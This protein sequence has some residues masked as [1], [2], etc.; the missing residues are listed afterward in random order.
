MHNGRRTRWPGNYSRSYV[1]ASRDKA[2]PF[3]TFYPSKRISGRC[4]T[5][6]LVTPSKSTMHLESSEVESMTTRQ[7]PY[8]TGSPTTWDNRG[9]QKLGA[10]LNLVLSSGMPQCPGLTSPSNCPSLPT[11]NSRP[12][13]RNSSPISFVNIDMFLYRLANLWNLHGQPDQPHSVHVRHRSNRDHLATYVR[14][15][16]QRRS[17]CRSIADSQIRGQPRHHR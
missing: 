5:P 7:S 15:I 2:G 13:C 10:D 6:S 1:D 14:T 4:S 16:R 3:S 8:C 17:P 11:R 12:T 9:D